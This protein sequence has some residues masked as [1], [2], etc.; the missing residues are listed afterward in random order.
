M[1]GLT[2]YDARQPTTGYSTGSGRNYDEEE[3]R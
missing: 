1:T 2:A 3:A